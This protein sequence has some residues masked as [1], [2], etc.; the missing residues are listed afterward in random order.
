M[1]MK[2]V[3]DDD[4]YPPE[5][6][7]AGQ[8]YWF[9][10]HYTRKLGEP[11]H[12]PHEPVP[13][14]GGFWPKNFPNDRK[15]RPYDITDSYNRSVASPI[16]DDDDKASS[17]VAII[18]AGP[19]EEAAEASSSTAPN[20]V[21]ASSPAGSSSNA[22]TSTRARSSSHGDIE[23]EVLDFTLDTNPEDDGFADDEDDVDRRP[24]PIIVSDDDDCSASDENEGGSAGG[25]V[26]SARQRSKQQARQ[27]PSPVLQGPPPE[28]LE[29]ETDRD[30]RGEINFN[31][32]RRR[33]KLRR[34]V[35]KARIRT[36]FAPRQVRPVKPPPPNPFSEQKLHDAFPSSSPPQKRKRRVFH[37]ASVEVVS[38]SSRSE[39]LD[40][41]DLL[42]LSSGFKIIGTAF[43][44]RARGSCDD[45]DDD[46]S[47]SQTEDGHDG[48]ARK[49]VLLKYDSPRLELTTSGFRI[50]TRRSVFIVGPPEDAYSPFISRAAQLLNIRAFVR[51]LPIRGAFSQ[52]DADV[53]A[54]AA[55]VSA[56][57]ESL[58]LQSPEEADLVWQ[59]RLPADWRRPLKT[60]QLDHGLA[61]C[62][63]DSLPNSPFVVPDVFEF[64]DHLLLPNSLRT[65]N[66]D[67]VRSRSAARRL[68]DLRMIETLVQEV[69]AWTSNK[70]EQLHVEARSPAGW[71]RNPDLVKA[72]EPSEVPV[73]TFRQAMIGETVYSVGDFVLVSPPPREEKP[74]EAESRPGTDNCT[75]S[76]FSDEDDEDSGDDEEDGEKHDEAD[77]NGRPRNKDVLQAPHHSLWFGCIEYFFQVKGDDADVV[78]AHLTYFT[79]S[80]AVPSTATYLPSD[81]FLLDSCS[82]IASESIIR[83]VDVAMLEPGCARPSE[84]FQFTYNEKD[85]SFSDVQTLEPKGGYTQCDRLNVV[86]CA[87]CE[88]DI[89]FAGT[90][91]VVVTLGRE[92][93]EKQKQLWTPVRF[94]GDAE[95]SFRYADKMYHPHDLVFLRPSV[96]TLPGDTSNRRTPLRLAQ[97]ISITPGPAKTTGTV[98]I[99][100]T[101][102]LGRASTL[103]VQWLV[104]R[105]EAGLYDSGDAAYEREIVW[106]DVEASG[107]DVNRLEG[108]FRL[109]HLNEVRNAYPSCGSDLEALVRY[110]RANPLNYWFSDAV[111]TTGSIEF[112]EDGR[113]SRSLRSRLAKVP[114]KSPDFRYCQICR[115]EEQQIGENAR[116]V[117]EIVNS[118]TA[119]AKK[120]QMASLACYAG[121]GMLD[122]G[123]KLGCQ[124]VK[125]GVAI[126]KDGAAASVF[127]ANNDGAVHVSAVSDH[128]EDIYFGKQLR[129]FV[130]LLTGGAP[131]Q[132]FSSANRY[133]KVDDPRC[134]EPVVFLSA[135]AL[136]RPLNACFENVYGFVQYDLPAHG[137]GKGSFFRAFIAFCVRLGYQVRWQVVNAAGYGVPQ[138]RRRVIIWLT[139]AGAP[140]PAS[141]K[142]THAYRNAQQQS[143]DHALREVDHKKP[144]RDKDAGSLAPHPCV[145]VE[146]AFGDLPDFDVCELRQGSGTF[147]S[148]PFGFA[149]GNGTG[150]Q[151]KKRPLTSFQLQSRAHPRTSTVVFSKA[152]TH[153]ICSALPVHHAERLLAI[154]IKGKDGAYGNYRDL[155]N[156]ICRPNMH[157]WVENLLHKKRDEWWA[158]LPRDGILAP[159]RTT[160]NLDG[161]SHGPR[162]HWSQSRGLSLRELMRAQG[163]PDQYE[164]LIAGAEHDTAFTDQIRIVGNGVPVP[165]AEA[166]GRELA[167]VLYPLILTHLA[168]G[169]E[170]DHTNLFEALWRTCGGDRLS[171]G[172]GRPSIFP[173]P[174]LSSSSST[175]RPTDVA[176]T[177]AA[178]VAETDVLV[179]SSSSSS[180]DDT[181]DDELVLSS[182]AEVDRGASGEA[183]TGRRRFSRS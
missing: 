28:D 97:I 94:K 171:V 3:W 180:D 117:E 109:R 174:P 23:Q 103:K 43:P 11:Q 56:A 10:D 118:H 96:M 12:D 24:E 89:R 84:G 102:C 81:L 139:L 183:R 52:S 151:Y 150:A 83:K 168:S 135:L 152:V 35:R 112:D 173:P 50:R 6:A 143:F 146:D 1:Y 13:E 75:R 90:T 177:T 9:L 136:L 167:K 163:L 46:S 93:E 128:L 40:F 148:R 107:I 30:V 4:D 62:L 159:L 74:G 120:Y 58:R 69:Q 47:R 71:R 31:A 124:A 114:S 92:G 101:T 39:R 161:A 153:H 176:A 45:G 51:T 27:R 15:N 21:S 147:E 164:L 22:F 41:L 125:T 106:T 141:P 149:W 115:T 122:L 165:L 144:K 156:L 91:E 169:T 126:E 179:L 181:S 70:D 123:L 178:L 182:R 66:P 72:G 67:A 53:K 127:K 14:S 18:S 68:A 29:F 57:L 140:L 155:E 78:F 175:S 8:K 25:K 119:S 170:S 42:R 157:S 162:I 160:L 138:A 133:K 7:S 108:L 86:R 131:C 172:I 99:P 59:H 110:E 79:M 111:R 121:G 105:K 154:G 158:R 61:Q 76:E 17:E 2:T 54:V 19:P 49:V 104:R 5:W 85:G 44:S 142:P 32:R 36:E 38:A 145:S 95:D 48:C 37:L 129:P 77:D 64:F 26:L 137:D 82:S 130:A 87:S 16:G 65:D 80:S 116:I 73:K 33:E 166:L 20:I 55:Q 60:L 63:F 100:G 88:H 132:G 34:Q 113:P 98:R 134:L